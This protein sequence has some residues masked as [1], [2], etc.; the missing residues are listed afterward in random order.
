MKRIYLFIITILLILPTVVNA[1]LMAPEMLSYDAIV[2]NPNGADYYESDESKVGTVPYGTEITVLY[3]DGSYANFEYKD[4]TY[5]IKLS[6][7]RST[8][9]KVSFN[10]K[11]VIKLDSK[12]TYSLV[13]LE[14]LKIYAGPGRAYNV[15]GSLKKYDKVVILYEQAIIES[16]TSLWG[17]I[18]YNGID[19]WIEAHGTNIASSSSCDIKISQDTSIYSSYEGKEVIGTIKKNTTI[20]K[21]NVYTLELAYNDY[22]YVRLDSKISGYIKTDNIYFLEYN[23]TYKVNEKTYLY[24]NKA[25]DI[26]TTS[27]KIVKLPK[28]SIVKV[29]Y[30]S[31]SGRYPSY[32]VEYNNQKGWVIGELLDEIEEKTTKETTTTTNELVIPPTTTEVINEESREKKISVDTIIIFSLLGATF[33]VLIVLIVLKILENKKRK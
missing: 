19:G 13:A 30:Y 11:D 31:I 25:Y 16:D 15:I 14:D 3:D 18:Q 24:A 2:K 27:K 17:G 20:S 21:N 26:E 9:D 8:K 6:D 10:D 23:K 7:I 12:N 29:I 32:Y 28:G 1:D 5:I 22:A 33:L 4:D